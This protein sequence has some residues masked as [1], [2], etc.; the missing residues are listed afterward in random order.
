MPG[1]REFARFVGYSIASS[2]ELEGHLIALRDLRVVSPS[3]FLALASDLSEVRKMLYGLLRSR[4]R[5]GKPPDDS[6][7]P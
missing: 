5:D 3:D 2:S 1:R 7:P 6:K 4:R